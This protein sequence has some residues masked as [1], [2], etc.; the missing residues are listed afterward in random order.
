MA[1]RVPLTRAK[2]AVPESVIRHL[3]SIRTH[4]EKTVEGSKMMRFD[5]P[6]E[7][8]PVFSTGSLLLDRAL[9][10]GGYPCGRIVEVYGPESSGKTTLTLHAIASAQAAGG[11]AA[12]VDAEHALDVKYAK[13]L[14]VKVNELLIT[15]PDYG[16]QALQIVDHLLDTGCM[17]QGDI[18]VVDSVAA[19]TPKVE[20][21]GEI[22]DQ[23]MGL[24]A[25]LMSQSMRMLA[26]KVHMSG[27]LLYFTNQQ[28]EK[29]GPFAGKVTTGGNALK[30]YA[31][32]RLDIR[33]TG[34]IKSGTGE[35]ATTV[36]N[37]VTINVVKNKLA[38]PFVQV[39]TIIR[40]GQGISR[41]DE[42]LDVGSD[43][44][45]VEKSG[46]WYS[47]GGERMGQGKE[48]AMSYL[49]TNFEVANKIEAAVRKA[50]AE[51]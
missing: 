12:F 2:I 40:F 33:R 45:I 24:H 28:R 41:L 6:V 50:M 25:R 47:Y 38:P 19:L 14:G 42:L 5:G 29:I 35:D 16:E 36:A 30:F 4:I 20:I 51:G 9:G 26:A 18:I 17:K 27:V 13:A 23:H 32:V 39:E 1:E 49:R 21:D 22:G 15:Q 37:N 7:A 43:M 3:D 8:C 44:G 34:S 11:V 10:I 48:N 31:S 46:S